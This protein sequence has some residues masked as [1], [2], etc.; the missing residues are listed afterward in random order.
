MLKMMENT[1]KMTI[2]FKMQPVQKEKK[3]NAHKMLKFFFKINQTTIPL[4]HD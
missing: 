1:M 3:K 4:F 2:E